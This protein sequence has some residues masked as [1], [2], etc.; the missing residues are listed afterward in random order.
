MIETD[1]AVVGAGPYG[2]SIAAHLQG[3]GVRFRHFGVPMQLW[4]GAMPAGMFLKSQGF[5]SNLSDP[6][7][8][9]TLREF[10]RE[11]GRD[12]GDYGVPVPLDTFVAYGD[13]FRAAYAPDL[14]ERLVERVTPAGD[15][16]ELAVEGGDVVRAAKVVF[17]PGVQYF[18][19]LPREFAGLPEG[20]CSHSS[21]HTDLGAFRGQDVIVVGAGQSALESAT[22]LHEH[23]ASV[24]LVARAHRLVW[25]GP[26]LAPDRPV[27]Q[28][29]REPE[30]G[31]GSGWSTWFYSTRPRLYRRLPSG[32]RVNRAR[33]ALG[34]A[35]GWWLRARAEGEFPVLL[36][37]SVLG[38][39]A[40]FGGVRLRVSTPDGHAH[41]ETQHVIAATG[42]R[43]SVRRLSFLDQGLQARLRQ[44]DGA[45]W[46]G[47]G[48]RSNVPGLFF[49]GPAV[50]ASFGPVMRF[51]YGADYAARTLSREL[52]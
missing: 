24:R 18:A 1:V 23:G 30:A 20:V 5:A 25:N 41:L 2:L 16:F 48:F 9:H 21:A 32:L 43:P 42:Y 39:E 34:P 8:K 27:L 7:G 47:P 6:Q 51:V 52:G 12:Y 13:W 4:R 17:A 38:C 15:R 14:D 29:W 28:R 33:T 22:L 49:A 10:C 36:G 26:P 37:R 11:T 40:I 31:L 3:L 44:I 45:P 46:V 35:G 50:A 19:H